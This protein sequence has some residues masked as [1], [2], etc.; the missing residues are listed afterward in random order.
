M[1]RYYEATQDFQALSIVGHKPSNTWIGASQVLD[2]IYA[3]IT[4]FA[5]DEV[6]DLI[7]GTF[8]VEDE[9]QVQPLTLA[10]NTRHIFEKSYGAPTPHKQRLERLIAEG[11]LVATDTPIKPKGYRT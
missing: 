6:H 9:D 8:H 4:V 7:G 3:E 2:P 10:K 11:L 1:N 5:G